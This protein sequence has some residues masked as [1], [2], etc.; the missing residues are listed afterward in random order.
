M[1]SLRVAELLSAADDVHLTILAEGKQL[2]TMKRD[3]ARNADPKRLPKLLGSFK[4]ESNAVLTGR[5]SEGFGYLLIAQWPAPDSPLMEPVHAALDTFIAEK[6]PAV[7]V[8]V[9]MNA[10]GNDLSALRLAERFAPGEGRVLPDADTGSR[11]TRRLDAV[12]FARAES[13]AGGKAFHG[14]GGSALRSALHEQ[15]RELYPYD[16]GRGRETRRRAH[17]RREWKSATI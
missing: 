5:T 13:R 17:I 10:G 11:T 1:F 8:D 3:V 2:P 9:R 7:I 15:Q 6:V 14:A 4:Q 12:A 16:A